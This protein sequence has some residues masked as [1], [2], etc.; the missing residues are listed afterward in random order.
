MRWYHASLPGP[1]GKFYRAYT[2]TFS[3]LTWKCDM[4]RGMKTIRCSFR[5]ST[6][7]RIPPSSLV[8]EPVHI[9]DSCGCAFWPF[10]HT[11]VTFC[12]PTES[13]WNHADGEKRLQFIFWVLP[14]ELYVS[15]LNGGGYLEFPMLLR[16]AHFPIIFDYAVGIDMDYSTEYRR[17]QKWVM[18]KF[19]N[20][21]ADHVKSNTSFLFYF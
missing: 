12:G 14:H 11:P 15:E 16:P 3:S 19:L 17:L 18:I 20:L 21:I 10:T 5:W 2:V 13:F 7:Y 6:R 4:I 1:E 9:E 8:T